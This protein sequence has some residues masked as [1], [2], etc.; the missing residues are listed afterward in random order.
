MKIECNDPD[1]SNQ[2][3]PT[4]LRRRKVR[5]LLVPTLRSRK[6]CE[7]KI[8]V[9]ERSVDRS[10]AFEVMSDVELLGHPHAAVQLNRLLT[11]EASGATDELLR[12]R[13]RAPAL[14]WIR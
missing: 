7:M 8:A 3:L 2:L 14:P 5:L 9:A 13:H 12:G 10:Q 1:Q 6:A 4:R 11:D